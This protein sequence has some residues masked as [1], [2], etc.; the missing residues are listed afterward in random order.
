VIQ[1]Q[2]SEDSFEAVCGRVD[3]STANLGRCVTVTRTRKFGT[4][5][6]DVEAN[7]S[8]MGARDALSTDDFVQAMSV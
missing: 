5:V 4:E 8:A 1:L 7:W 2:I 6:L 3:V